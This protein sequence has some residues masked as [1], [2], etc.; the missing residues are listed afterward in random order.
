[1]TT[2]SYQVKVPPAGVQALPGQR[3]CPFG[4]HFV[5]QDAVTPGRH[6]NCRPCRATWQR[7]PIHR[8]VYNECMR[9]R[10]LRDSARAANQPPPIFE[11]PNNQDSARARLIAQGISPE[12]EWPPPIKWEDIQMEHFTLT[13]NYSPNLWHAGL[14]FKPLSYATTLDPVRYFD[15]LE[16]EIMLA[17][18]G[19][20]CCY[21]GRP[22]SFEYS[23]G[24]H[25]A[26]HSKFGQTV[27]ENHAAACN[28]CNYLKLS[29]D[30]REWFASEP[31]RL[32]VF[33]EIRGG[34]QADWFDELLTIFSQTGFAQ[35]HRREQ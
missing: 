28:R 26:P 18:Q 16:T 2:T 1:M 32:L 22:L 14:F 21:C 19:G 27:T 3:W 5:N 23:K 17:I 34:I 13:A 31:R 33:I 29:R 15:R 20:R 10:R 6:S 30:P 24:E 25:I 7:L 9:R 35:A 12:P 11:T 8:E 4:V